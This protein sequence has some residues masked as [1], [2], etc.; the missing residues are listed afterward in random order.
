MSTCRCCQYY[1]PEGRRGGNC[2]QLGVPVR[3]CWKACSIGSP[4]FDRYGSRLQ[5]DFAILE[6][7]LMLD[8]I[9]SYTV[10][11]QSTEVESVT[12]A[13]AQIKAA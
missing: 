13:K 7:S 1:K 3:G 12:M 11:E 2:Q 10:A 8:C 9:P 4:A 6:N 5:E